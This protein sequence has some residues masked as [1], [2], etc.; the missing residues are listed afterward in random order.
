VFSLEITTAFF[1]PFMPTSNWV[2][3]Q[4][5]HPA[6]EWGDGWN[7]KA[8][9]FAPTSGSCTAGINLA[10]AVRRRRAPQRSYQFLPAP[11]TD[12]RFTWPS[13]QGHDEARIAVDV[14][15]EGGC[16]SLASG[17]RDVHRQRTSAGDVQPESRDLAQS[18]PGSRRPLT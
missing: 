2:L 4:G 14:R 3:T 6:W 5:D 16:L 10:A 1:K 11:A 13:R 18:V 7:G 15:R 9:D 12:R 8:R 17:F